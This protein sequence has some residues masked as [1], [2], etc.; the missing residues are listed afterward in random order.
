[1]TIVI[2]ILNWNSA[3]R[4]VA[5]LQSLLAIKT[6]G[7]LVCVTDNHS[8]NFD[9]QAFEDIHPGL[10]V[11]ENTENLGFAGG[12]YQ[13][14]SY[15]KEIGANA[16][17]MLNNDT[18]V[19]PDTLEH[20]LNAYHTHG[21]GVYGS[22][23]VNQ[24]GTLNYQLIWELEEKSFKTQFTP[25]SQEKLDQEKTLQVANVVGYSFMI[26]MTVI[27]QHGFM[28]SSYFLYYEE[29]DY[30]FRLLGENIP[31]Y[32]V[33]SSKVYHEKEGS[34]NGRPRLKEIM[35]YYLYRNLFFFLKRHGSTQ[36]IFH[37]LGRFGMRFLSAN[38]ARKQ[39][40]PLLTWKHLR[41]I[42]HAFTGKKGPYYHP[43]D[44]L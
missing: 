8:L 43:E 35:E 6:P 31:S 1:M 20:L 13:A 44:Y 24:A 36:I 25:L 40:V 27:E 19:F 17:W 37:Y 38:I 4:T 30:C 22:A 9:R 12:Q 11:F 18:R 21:D 15:A 3:D 32:W 23:A 28:D 42:F 26:P 16:F 5:C 41:G 33:G 34:T 10:V 29:T 14:L 2:S 7:L 39:K